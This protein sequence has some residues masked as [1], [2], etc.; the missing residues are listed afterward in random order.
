M[1]VSRS[2]TITAPNPRAGVIVLPRP[3]LTRIDCP[4]TLK[5][6][7][8]TVPIARVITNGGRFA[9]GQVSTLPPRR[10]HQRKSSI[11]CLRLARVASSLQIARSSLGVGLP[12]HNHSSNSKVVNSGNLVAMVKVAVIGGFLWYS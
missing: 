6:E 7:E 5:S 12:T 3:L 11:A 10:G 1:A 8:R 4:C 9:Q 2:A